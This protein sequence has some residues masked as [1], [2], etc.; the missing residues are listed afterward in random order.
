MCHILLI[1]LHVVGFQWA[2]TALDSKL[3]EY[4]V[5]LISLKT[6]QVIPKGKRVKCG[7]VN[8]VLGR[9][10]EAGKTIVFEPCW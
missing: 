7:L 3:W 10:L 8:A 6:L 5:N 9:G 1:T 4:H 2:S